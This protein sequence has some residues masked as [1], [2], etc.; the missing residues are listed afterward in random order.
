MAA[1]QANVTTGIRANTKTSSEPVRPL[2]NFPPSV[3]GHRFLSFS[4][5]KSELE[6][7]AIAMEKPKEEVRKLIVDP[8]MDSNEKLGLIYSVHRLGLT[9]MFLQ[10]IESQ[11]D[12]LFNEF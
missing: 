6:R 11:L 3:W 4:L 2:A 7:Y 8:T 5:D 12:K 9:Y 1:V 10:E